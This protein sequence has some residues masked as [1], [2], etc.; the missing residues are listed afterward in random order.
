MGASSSRYSPGIM[1]SS[2]NGMVHGHELRA[3]RKRRFHLDFVNHLR[4][5]IHDV[6]VGE[7][8]PARAHELG[9]ASP[10]AC[11]FEKLAGDQGDCLGIVE[12]ETTAF[13]GFREVAGDVNQQLIALL[14]REMHNSDLSICVIA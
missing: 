3:I 1:T 11:P 14:R 7:D 6:G 5:A 12:L 13:A 8:L 10:I 4:Y 9:H 2:T